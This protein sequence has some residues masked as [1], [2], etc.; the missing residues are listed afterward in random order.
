MRCSIFARLRANYFYAATVQE[1][2]N[3]ICQRD[4]S[5]TKFLHDNNNPFTA[6]EE[7]ASSR[8]E[9]DA[10]SRALMKVLQGSKY[11]LRC[12]ILNASYINNNR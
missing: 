5:E 10:R 9:I 7:T 3:K 6:R 4:Y 1:G 2:E 8:E 11:F 12:I